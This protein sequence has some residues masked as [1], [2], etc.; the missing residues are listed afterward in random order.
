[1]RDE[2]GKSVPLSR[3][4]TAAWPLFAVSGGLP[5]TVFGEWDGHALLPLS[6]IAGGRFISLGSSPT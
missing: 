1:L 6:A 4:F 3:R 2:K 5:V